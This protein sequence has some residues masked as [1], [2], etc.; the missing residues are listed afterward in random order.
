MLFTPP[1]ETRG[2][3]ARRG[4]RHA[5]V[6]AGAQG[7]YGGALATGDALAPTRARPRSPRCPTGPAAPG[8]W[9][10]GVPTAG[11]TA[12]AATAHDFLTFSV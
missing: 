6:P 11:T 12:G 4:A 2:E 10:I 1:G 7:R 8:R 9:L 5:P 3:A